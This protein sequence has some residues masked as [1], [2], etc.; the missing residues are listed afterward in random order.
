MRRVLDAA[1]DA[2]PHQ[3]ARA[4]RLLTLVA[5]IAENVVT[6][7]RQDPEQY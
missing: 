2:E 1:I 4:V 7:A 6:A 3:G 5:P